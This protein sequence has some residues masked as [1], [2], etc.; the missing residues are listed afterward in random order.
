MSPSVDSADLFV[1]GRPSDASLS[2]SDSHIEVSQPAPGPQ[3]LSSSTN[4]ENPSTTLSSP[5]VDWQLIWERADRSCIEPSASDLAHLSS[6]P[7]H[8]S[9][10]PPY[11]D[12]ATPIPSED[13]I[14]PDPDGVLLDF[15]RH[16]C[17]L[18]SSMNRKSESSQ[19]VAIIREDLRAISKQIEDWIVASATS[20]KL[21]ESHALDLKKYENTIHA[22]EQENVNLSARL[23]SLEGEVR[24][25][26]AIAEAWKAEA[27]NVQNMQEIAVSA[28][29]RCNFLETEN[30]QLKQTMDAFA[31][32]STN[33][34]VKELRQIIGD[35]TREVAQ[36]KRREKALQAKETQ[37]RAK[38]NASIIEDMRKQ[39]EELKRRRSQ[40]S[41]LQ[42]K[43]AF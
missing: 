24:D 22:L 35:L 40:R 41:V 2:S 27:R 14:V 20:P 19:T 12:D 21:D 42:V 28:F 30:V 26:K 23:S 36:Y 3:T 10:G 39:T 25:A 16:I 34:T 1:L 5:I 18:W 7:F 17:S 38:E 11:Q 8:D 9:S 13:Y 31:E 33:N 6:A 4:S 37:M 32:G 15:S 29:E 43:N